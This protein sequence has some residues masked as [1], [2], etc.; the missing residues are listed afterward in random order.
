[1]R[2]RLRTYTQYDRE[3]TYIERRSDAL[4]VAKC[5]ARAGSAR[6][7][8]GVRNGAI[9]RIRDR[10]ADIVQAEVVLATVAEAGASGA[11]NELEARLTESTAVT[12]LIIPHVSTLV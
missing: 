1:M 5:G 10:L 7:A 4:G 11:G 2:I 8:C 9:D 3:C 12:A 6:S